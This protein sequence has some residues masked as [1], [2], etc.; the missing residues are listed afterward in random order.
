LAQADAA[1]GSAGDPLADPAATTASASTTSDHCA[2][3]RTCA[4]AG[5]QVPGNVEVG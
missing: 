5:I 4:Y 2:D 1:L 3:D